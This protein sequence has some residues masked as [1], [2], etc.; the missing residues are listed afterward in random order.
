MEVFK[1]LLLLVVVIVVAGGVAD[2]ADRTDRMDR[3]KHLVV[4][5]NTKGK[6]SRRGTAC[7]FS[8]SRMPVPSSP[9]KKHA[10][11]QIPGTT[12]TTTTTKR[13][14]WRYLSTH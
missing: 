12:T 1:L 11:E 9:C 7:D 10:R 13:Q 3:I 14:T 6:L 4:K 5:V 8:S 2:R